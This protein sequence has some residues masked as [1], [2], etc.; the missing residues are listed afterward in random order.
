MDR[1]HRAQVQLI[2]LTTRHSAPAEHKQQEN[3]D[4]QDT[5]GGLSQLI[6][7]RLVVTTQQ[8]HIY[9]G[10]RQLFRLF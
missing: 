9:T 2:Q 3:R 7:M 1:V 5:G 10:S 4:T 6:V 8:S